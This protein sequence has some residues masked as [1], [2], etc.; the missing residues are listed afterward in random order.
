MNLK[1]KIE[2]YVP[3]NEQEEADK[4]ELLRI[5]ELNENYFIRENLAAH[6][7]ASGWVVSPDRTKTLLAYH[8]LYDSWAW[9]GGHADGETDLLSVALKE[10]R[11]ESR[12]KEVFPVS[13]DV[14]SLEILP[15]FGHEKNGKYVS[16]HLHLNVTFLLEADPTAEIHNNPDENSKV[17]WFDLDDVPRVST[18]T[19][20]VHRI[21]RKLIE[22]TKENEAWKPEKF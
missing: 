2:R 19:W 10:V 15:V 16:S 7:T 21:Y 20:F 14:F 5:L 22:K 11:E 9:L 6:F 4:Q 13:E 17:G 8:N 18:E 12:L 1:E 3:Y